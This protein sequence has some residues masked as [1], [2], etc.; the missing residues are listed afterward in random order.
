MESRIQAYIDAVTEYLARPREV[1]DM[2][3]R[4]R[5]EVAEDEFSLEGHRFYVMEAEFSNVMTFTKARLITVK[6]IEFPDM[7][8]LS[9]AY[10][11]DFDDIQH[12]VNACQML[13]KKFVK[14]M[15]PKVDYRFKIQMHNEEVERLLEEL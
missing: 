1:C 8:A 11:P 13:A 10:E 9:I 14:D 12:R 15:L 7:E 4:S 3:L 5:W 2:S 6:S